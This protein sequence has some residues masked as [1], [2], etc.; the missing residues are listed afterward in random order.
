MNCCPILAAD[1]HEELANSKNVTKYDC[2]I[3]VIYR[4]TAKI[5]VE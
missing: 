5:Y 1:V 4:A 2:A 3:F